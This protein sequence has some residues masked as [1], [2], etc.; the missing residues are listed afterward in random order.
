MI[1]L[2]SSPLTKELNPAPVCQ[3]IC[4]VQGRHDPLCSH[5]EWQP[6]W[7]PPPVH[8]VIRT[9]FWARL[10]LEGHRHCPG[11]HFWQE[12]W[13]W[14]KRGRLRSLFQRRISGNWL[15]PRAWGTTLPVWLLPS[16]L[17]FSLFSNFSLTTYKASLHTERAT[18]DRLLVFRSRQS[19]AKQNT[20]KIWE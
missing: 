13:F 20:G 19:Q 12:G 6:E 15:V 11:H 4:G 1:Y 9:G 8:A 10:L 2:F 16:F 5:C 14:D 17:H 7:Q 3:V 18:Q